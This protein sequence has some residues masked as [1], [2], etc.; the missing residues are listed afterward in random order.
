MNQIIFD[1]MKEVFSRSDFS[2]QLFG[3]RVL[4]TGAYG[5]LA[6]YFVF[7][8]IFLNE[9]QNQESIEI[10][11]VGRSYEKMNSR[12]GE[13]IDRPYFHSIE[14]D[15]STLDLDLPEVD[16]IIHAA[17]P[18]S[19]EFYA[20]N[21]IGVVTPNVI[22][23]WGLLELAKRINCKS[24]LFVSSGEVYGKTDLDSIKEDEFGPSNPL[25]IRYCYGES[26]RMGECLCKCYNHQW[27][28]PVKMVRLGHTYGPTMNIDHDKRV[29]AEFTG[30]IVRNEN[31]L[32]KSSGKSMRAFC[33]SAD[34]LDGFLRILL[35]GKNGESY[36]LSNA[37]ALI[38]ISDLAEILVRL[39]PDKNL[40]VEY[41][42]RNKDEAYIES[43]QAKH[44]VP[45][46]T[47]LQELGWECRYDVAEGFRRSVLSFIGN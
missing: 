2:K 4:V 28:V 38:S 17:S 13:Y 39:F 6:S 19:S 25:D 8:L 45:D 35:C 33:Y 26:K 14:N 46:S 34:A 24:M 44:A 29:Y 7:Y 23:T 30:N 11:A 36:N 5:M 9:T 47:K 37:S 27:N 22:G 42:S 31:I 21:P 43:A 12:F 20:T 16:Y 1:D 10:Y 18:A 41:G 32:I 40:C 3:K 15:L